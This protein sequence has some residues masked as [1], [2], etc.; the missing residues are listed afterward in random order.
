[1]TKSSEI[2]IKLGFYLKIINHWS[3]SGEKKQLP[4]QAVPWPN[5]LAWLGRAACSSV[6]AILK[7]EYFSQIASA[8]TTRLLAG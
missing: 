3:F 4:K 8:E 5:S 2:V 6:D 1:M 7:L